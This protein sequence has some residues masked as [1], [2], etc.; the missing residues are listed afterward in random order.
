MVDIIGSPRPSRDPPGASWLI[1]I[2]LFDTTV[3]YTLEG[4]K[5]VLD[6]PELDSDV[7]KI[8]ESHLLLKVV[9]F[10]EAIAL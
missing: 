7:V 1:V 9:E 8:E 3:Q 10:I 5:K 4:V 2:G 6:N